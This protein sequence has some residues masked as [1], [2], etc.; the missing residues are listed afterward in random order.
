MTIAPELA[1]SPTG[2]VA[3]PRRRRRIRWA[4]LA[5]VAL[6]LAAGTAFLIKV[7]TERAIGVGYTAGAR[8][9]GL[10]EHQDP[11][12]G[13]SPPGSWAQVNYQPGHTITIGTS[14]QNLSHTQSITVT[15]LVFDE[16]SG[17]PRLFSSASVAY[18][19]SG[20][21]ITDHL[22]HPFTLG[23]RQYVYVEWSLTMCSTGTAGKNGGSTGVG[24][25]T[26]GYRYFGFTKH[27]TVPLMMPVEFDDVLG[28]CRN[29][30]I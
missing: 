16:S 12:L 4:V 24:D 8:G 18:T 21:G 14:F 19:L 28:L 2:D 7:G 5:I 27:Q 9:S 25:Y 3:P 22:F 1:E 15:S 20:G 23:P 13:Q 10:V 29:P 17:Y 11:F 6:M 26:I 30:N